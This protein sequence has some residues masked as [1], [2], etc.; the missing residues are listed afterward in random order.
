MVG[1]GVYGLAC[2][3]ACARRGLRVLVAEATAPG[4]GASGGPVGALAPH[5]P[6]PWSPRKAAQL[7]AL[8]GAEAYWREVAAEGGVDPGY[9]RVGRAIPLADAAARARAAAQI[10]AA[11]RR[12]GGAGSWRIA[13]AGAL[14]GWIAPA[15]APAGIALETLSARLAPRRAVAALAA[16]AASRGVEIRRG[17]R[18][19]ALGPGRARFAEGEV[20]AGVVVLAAGMAC[21]RLAPGLPVTG[22]KGQAARLDA[23][24]PPGA[25]LL[26]ADGLYVA[27]CP[28]GGVAVGSTA[29]A[30]WAAA[31]STD[32]RLDAVIAR[33]RRLCPALAGAATLERW[34]G[35]RPR[36]PR[37][38]PMVGPIPGLDRALAAT[39]GF[40]TGFATAPAAAEA[41]AALALGGAAILPP[42][43]SVA[44]HL[45]AAARRRE[46]A[47]GDVDILARRDASAPDA[48]DSG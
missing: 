35:V 20:A 6:E 15:A 10:E 18:A 30:S 12:W 42:G 8:A 7:A 46:R 40:R 1:A 47:G 45:E 41:V 13:E 9:A 31:S 2:A 26:T 22:V 19:V 5:P 17:W 38:D 24:A 14:P 3:L 33:A 48:V 32:A 16:A 29:E 11:R 27:P 28:G 34:A 37:P 21:A 25:P 23:A 39:G 43:W 36:A 44:D 4:A